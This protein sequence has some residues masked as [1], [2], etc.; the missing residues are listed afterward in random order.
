MATN[1]LTNTEEILIKVD[2]NN[3]ICIDPNSVVDSDGNVQPRGIQQENL[4]MYVNLEADLVPRTTLVNNDNKNTMVSIAGGQLN[5]MRN[6][7]GQDFDSTW[8]DTYTPSLTGINP[9]LQQKWY[10]TSAQSFGIESVNIS[11]NSAAIPKVSIMFT[12]VRGKTLFE[13]PEN[14]PYKA[15]F[16][17]PWPIFY[18]TVKGF[19]GK[20]IRYRLHLVKFSSKYNE[21]NGNFEISTDFVGSTFAYLSDIPLKGIINAPYMFATE[22]TTKPVYNPSTKMYDKKVSKSSRGYSMLKSVYAE[23]KQKG[24]LPQDFPVKTLREIAVVAQTLDKL[25]EAEILSET[26]NVDIFKVLKEM[27]DTIVAYENEVKT[28]AR[29]TLTSSAT[30]INNVAYYYLLGTGADKTSGA[31]IIG[32]T[33]TNTLESIITKYNK[34]LQ[35]TQTLTNKIKINTKSKI[36]LTKVNVKLIG[37]ISNYYTTKGTNYVVAIDKLYN[38]IQEIQRTFEEQ[39]VK[40]ETI[41]EEK[42]NEI[43]KDPKKGIGFAPTVKNIFAVLL[44]NADVFI[45]LMKQTHSS[46][47]DVSEKRKSIIKGFSTETIGDNIYPWPEIKKQVNND[48]KVPVYPGNPDMVSKL[49][50]DDSALWPEVDF[51]ENYHGIST[52]KY[53]PL[54]EKE[55]G[56]NQIN[57]IFD[58]NSTEYNSSKIGALS[59]LTKFIPYSEQIPASILYEIYERAYNYTIFDS[60]NTDTL[61]E[62][63]IIEYSNLSKSVKENDDIN[64]LLHDKIINRNTLLTYLNTYSPL[65]RYPYYQ[66]NLPTTGYLIDAIGKSFKIEQYIPSTGISTDYQYPKLNDNL[67]NYTLDDDRKF[68]YPFSSDLYL[69]YQKSSK[70]TYSSN[71]I[72]IDG[73]LQV[74]TINGFICSPKEPLSWVKINYGYTQNLFNQKLFI[75]DSQVNILNTPYFHKQLYSDFNN[76][77]NYGKYAGSAY[78]LLNSLPFYDLEDN[79]GFNNGR[80]SINMSTLFKEI[81]ATHTIPYHLIIKWGSIY[82]RYKNYLLNGVDIL[83]PF[84]TTG[85]TTTVV[86]GNEFFNNNQTGPTFTSYTISNTE[87]V[88]SGSSSDLGIHPYYDAI[89]HNVVN[90]YAHYDI[91]T[92]NTSFNANV[93]NNII[94]GSYKITNGKRYWTSFV[95]NSKFDSGDKRYT[96]LPSSGGND[97]TKKTLITL[98][99]S[100]PIAN[101]ETFYNGEQSN[102]RLIW[103]DEVVGLSVDFSGRTFPSYGEYNRTY[104]SGNTND[105]LYGFD[106]NFR[107]VIDLIG[108]FSPSILDDFESI[109]LEFATE[110]INSLAPF[111]RFDKVNYYKFQDLLKDIVSVP[112]NNGDD[113]LSVDNLIL[114]LKTRQD[115]NLREITNKILSTENLLSL[116][117]TNPKE[118]NPY[119]FEGFILGT[120]ANTF[121]HLPFDSGQIT[122][123]NLKAIKLYVGEDIDNNYINFFSTNNVE[124]SVDNVLLF[125]PLIL[126]Y[127]GY[128]NNGNAVGSQSFKNY[129]ANNIYGKSAALPK[130]MGFT[131][132]L[133]FFLD[134]LI[135][136][137]KNLVTG[138]TNRRID[139]TG[140]YNIDGLKLETY[141]YFKSINDKWIAGNSIGQRNLIEEFLF[142][143]RAN[144]DIGD[145]FYLNLDR[146]S[147]LMDD[148]NIRQSLYGAIS[149][150]IQGTGLDMR[151]LPAYVNFYG[152]NFSNVGK[153]TPSKNV[154]KNLF[155]TFLEVDYQESSPKV[156]IQLVGSS[157]N[158]LSDMDHKV[159]KFADDSFNISQIN[160]NPL[161][162]TLPEVYSPGVL[163]KSNKV[164]AFEVSFGDENQGI[165]KGVTLN[166]DSLKNT[167]EAF[168]VME[169]LGRSESGAGT[170][171]VD[172]GLFDYYRQASYTCTVTCMGNVMIQ[173]TMYFY[174]K[175]IPMFKGTYWV[176]DVSH[177]IKNNSIT[178]TFK[179]VRMPIS[180]FPDPKDSFLSSYR[181][182]FDKI[183]NVATS[184]VKDIDLK[185]NST[186][187]N[188]TTNQG[189][190][191]TDPG[192]LLKSETMDMIMTNSA[193]ANA[194]GVHFNGDE[195]I[196]PTVQR[197]KF[198][199]N[200]DEI[201]LRTRVIKMGGAN[202]EVK[203]NNEMELIHKLNTD[204]RI[205]DPKKL[206]WSEI[207]NTGQYFFACKFDL[208]YTTADYIASATT[209]FYNPNTK[210]DLFIL[211]PNYQ[212]NKNNG[213]IQVQGAV[214]IIPNSLEYGIVMSGELMRKLGLNEK[215]V[216]YFK[217]EKK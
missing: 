200:A 3:L 37:T 179:G 115:I 17:V 123:T 170:Y 213:K 86:S 176:M 190:F 19:Y 193:G 15:F 85:N 51:V 23:Y 105:N 83:E 88:Y 7:N 202:Y 154:A 31:K 201:W 204:L 199:N 128:V 53:D 25:L 175:S 99:G 93:T 67:L 118:I 206:P 191:K 103:S 94:N 135:A 104:N 44:A 163:S 40:F 26:V 157:S 195:N 184:K 77:V 207:K 60:F 172:V 181:S 64:V 27:N 35:D 161:I 138:T 126:S 198:T 145:R 90:N 10:D 168:L 140:G 50:S 56:V 188:V 75:G 194:F 78:L 95:D 30:T 80:T 210:G 133:N 117:I 143:D 22:S 6:Q 55:G 109:F 147:A 174:L 124:L 155:G 173:P 177:S 91:T 178:T 39:R 131:N 63:A 21:N 129:L 20:A 41:I 162:V 159:Y 29:T 79:I 92:G 42:M 24:Y 100:I 38:E 58:S 153:I 11:I 36:D 165:F 14:S 111:I 87:I 205:I 127:A 96:L 183:K 217:M 141:N 33:T 186:T 211:Q 101:I 122:E 146:I 62:L 74:D 203:D 144:R 2:Q 212:L 71:N 208:R 121:S 169:N 72:K 34:Q 66:D 43:V 137:F 151:A 114:Q 150:L 156:I 5:F 68:I 216:V 48:Q 110:K 52:Q 125:R 84:L 119:M 76:G 132:R 192:K 106:R 54:G 57:Y 171:N 158:H 9:H 32:T 108:T 187:I 47:F 12:D 70:S 214:D 97:I 130:S 139:I 69:S 209:T 189:N 28:W 18:L 8:T 116:T 197:V 81:G 160:N 16:H 142:L 65:Q 166:Q 149:L 112:K 136:Q 182:L 49:K 102:L 13:S 89:Y 167:T 107:K 120:T 180:P 59:Y 148:N 215:D 196:D 4:V 73:N 45:R 61:S 134:I 98:T 185:T 1:N 46:A 152:T 113:N 164:V 82:H